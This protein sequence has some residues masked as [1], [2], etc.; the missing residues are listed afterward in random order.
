MFVD[1]TTYIQILAKYP[2]NSYL[3]SLVDHFFFFLLSENWTLKHTKKSE[4][5]KEVS[6]KI[7]TMQF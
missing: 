7:A 6:L 4:G 2:R 3:L 1:I 5:G